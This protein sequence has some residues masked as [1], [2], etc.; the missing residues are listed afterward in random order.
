MAFQNPIGPQPDTQRMVQSV[1]T[2]ADSFSEGLTK[3]SNIPATAQGNALQDTLTQTLTQI[4][5]LNA[6]MDRMEAQLNAL[7]THVSTK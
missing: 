4:T 1:H 5:Q 2:F 3:L 6:R 7:I